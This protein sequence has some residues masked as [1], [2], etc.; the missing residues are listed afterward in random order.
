MF[1]C[2]LVWSCVHDGWAS[3]S[4][5]SFI[6]N[7]RWNS[8]F[9][10]VALIFTLKIRVDRHL[11]YNY[12]YKVRILLLEILSW[13]SLFIIRIVISMSW[14]CLSSFSSLFFFFLSV[15]CG[16]R[17]IS[18]GEA[19]IQTLV[20]KNGK[21]KFSV[22]CTILYFLVFRWKNNDPN[23]T[24]EDGKGKLCILCFSESCFQDGLS[25]LM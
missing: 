15:P 9:T 21:G 23:L 3:C 12:F 19:T 2:L 22:I 13:L 5:S 14:S 20:L 17:Q 18:D 25:C 6:R 7:S 1:S 16:T 11:L 8:K 10:M 24:L 4:I